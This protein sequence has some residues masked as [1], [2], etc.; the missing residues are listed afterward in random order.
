MQYEAKAKLAVEEKQ[1]QETEE[2]RKKVTDLV[3]KASTERK[4]LKAG[5]RE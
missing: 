2:E 3:E 5:S 1:R 4:F